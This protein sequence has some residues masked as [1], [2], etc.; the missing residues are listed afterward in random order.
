MPPPS[1]SLSSSPRRI[2]THRIASH[3]SAG[4]P[5]NGCATA[6]ASSASSTG[7]LLSL[8]LLQVPLPSLSRT[9]LPDP[10][11]YFTLLLIVRA[12]PPSSSA[13]ISISLLPPSIPFIYRRLW[14]RQVS[15]GFLR[16]PS[17]RPRL[18]CSRF[19]AS[20][21]RRESLPVDVD[22]RNRIFARARAC[23][24]RRTPRDRPADPAAPL[25]PQ[26]L[27][28]GSVGCSSLRSLIHRR[29]TI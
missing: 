19:R 15:C 4:R 7:S 10:C 28:I 14:H 21:S 25:Q 23:A 24:S 17:T 22:P 9:Y 8:F 11:L 27:S 5:H 16:H 26:S 13:P 12:C 6:R 29:V 1:S 20:P 18:P 3:R 2:A